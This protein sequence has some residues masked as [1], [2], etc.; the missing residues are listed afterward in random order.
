M[1]IFAYSPLSFPAEVA[2]T[3]IFWSCYILSEENTEFW[4]WMVG[5]TLNNV[6][7]KASS[8]F[9]HSKNPLGLP[10]YPMKAQL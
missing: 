6:Y 1:E 8:C 10:I 3:S 4:V 5:L 7:T 2:H 9:E